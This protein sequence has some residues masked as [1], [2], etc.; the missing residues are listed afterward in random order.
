V[1]HFIIFWHFCPEGVGPI[2]VPAARARRAGAL[3]SLLDAPFRWRTHAQAHTREPRDRD[4]RPEGED[5]GGGFDRNASRARPEGVAMIQGRPQPGERIGIIDEL[6]GLALIMVVL[7]HVGLVYGLETD[8][9]YSL[10]LPAFGVGVD[11]FLVISGFV[12]YR[13]VRAMSV[14]AGGN[15]T[16]GAQ[17][18]WVRRFVRIAA[19]AAGTLAVVGALRLAQEGPGASWAD[20][21]AALAFFANF[22]WAGCAASAAPCPHA[23][24]ASHFWSLS[25]EGQF[26]AVA[27]ALIA[28]PRH[29]AL[30]A[31]LAVLAMGACLERPLGSY[32]WTTRPD[33][34]FIGMGLAALREQAVAPSK[35]WPSLSLGQ[36][37]YWACVASLFARLAIGR[38][39]GLGLT[40]VSL[41]FG[42]VLA[43]R[44]GANAVDSWP[45]R[46]LRKGGE[47]S[48]SAYLVHLPVM[49]GVHVALAE[50]TAPALSLLASLAAIPAATLI[51]EALIVAPAARF[52][53]RLSERWILINRK[54]GADGCDLGRQI[55][56]SSG[57]ECE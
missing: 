9:G 57:T 34:L 8:I 5:A 13:N 30:P 7:S 26:Y 15:A 56:R 14:K 22:Y 1:E 29:L 37:A 18:F 40:F 23:L 2:A 3:A 39:S 33:A 41:L 4:R 35:F 53:R 11:L 49:S 21:A 50:R 46:A 52:G 17:A 10:A 42:L 27:P 24:V 19:P 28:L 55:I 43:G 48:F 44:L 12:I 51:W 45:A 31:C 6:R 47:L 54:P 38:F 32:L 25:L 16:L 20:L 36:A